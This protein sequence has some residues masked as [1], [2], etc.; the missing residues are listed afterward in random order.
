LIKHHKIFLHYMLLQHQNLLEGLS[1]MNP[2]T[3]CRHQ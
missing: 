3:L 2:K 1:L